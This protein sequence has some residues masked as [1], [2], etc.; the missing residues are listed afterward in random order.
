MQMSVSSSLWRCSLPAMFVVE[1][2]KAVGVGGYEPLRYTKAG[3]IVPMDAFVVPFA[4]PKQT[5][6]VGCPLPVACRLLPVADQLPA[7]CCLL[8]ASCLFC[9]LRVAS[10]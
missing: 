8:R 10:V 1:K 5:T 2:G 4:A 6:A 7:A 3:K 9:L